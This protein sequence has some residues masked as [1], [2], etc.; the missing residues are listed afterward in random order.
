MVTKLQFYLNNLRQKVNETN[1]ETLEVY[2]EPCQI[3]K[4]EIFQKIANGL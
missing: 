1:H 2:S 4:M 3:P